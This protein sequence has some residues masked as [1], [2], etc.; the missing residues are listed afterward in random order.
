MIRVPDLLG[1]LVL[2]AAAYESDH[3]DVRV[4]HLYDAALIASL[5]DDPDMQYKRLHS[6]ND[7]RRLRLLQQQLTLD[8]GYWQLLNMEHTR[9]GLDTLK[10]L[11]Q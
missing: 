4:R 5:I 3:T 10:V 11:A 9:N 6:K 2:K 1:A 8:S 7:H